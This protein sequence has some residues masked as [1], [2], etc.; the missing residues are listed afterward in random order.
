[1]SSGAPGNSGGQQQFPQMQAGQQ[2]VPSIGPQQNRPNIPVPLQKLLHTLKS[3][4]SPQQKAKVLQIL[5][6]HPQLMAEFIKQRQFVQH[7]QQQQEQQGLQ[8]GM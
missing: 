5:K 6:R 4:D 1:M 2:G 8:Q 3:P 7:Q